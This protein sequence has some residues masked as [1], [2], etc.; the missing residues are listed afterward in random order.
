MANEIKYKTGGKS[1]MEGSRWVLVK[2]LLLQLGG[3]GHP[4]DGAM[5]SLFP[6]YKISILGLSIDV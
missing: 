6:D 4:Q 3:C 2:L 1:V 5:P